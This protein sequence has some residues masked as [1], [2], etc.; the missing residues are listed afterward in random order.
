MK[1]DKTFGIKFHKN[2]LLTLQNHLIDK[3]VPLY[4]SATEEELLLC[5][6]DWKYGSFFTT[7]LTECALYLPWATKQFKNL[8]GD[9]Q[10]VKLESFADVPKNYDMVIN[11]TGLGAKY[12]CNDHK[13]VPIRGQV[14]K[15][16][17]WCYTRKYY[18]LSFFNT[19]YISMKKITR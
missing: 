18:A 19:Y 5:P 4:R 12:L 8:G 13:L 2:F 16:K 6:G 1:F 7:I 9:I 14:L 3:V 10:H 11:C 15:V 17:N